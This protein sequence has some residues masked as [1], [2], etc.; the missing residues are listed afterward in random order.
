MLTSPA[1]LLLDPALA[2]AGSAAVVTDDRQA[3]TG[4]EIVIRIATTN[5]PESGAGN[6]GNHP[7]AG[8]VEDDTPHRT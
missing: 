1:S 4:N 5:L 8:R 2:Y 7:L 6:I 3:S